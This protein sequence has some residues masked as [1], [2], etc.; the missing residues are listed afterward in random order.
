ML[1]TIDHTDSCVPTV[2]GQLMLWGGTMTDD[3]PVWLCVAGI[4]IQSLRLIV[5]CTRSFVLVVLL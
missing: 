5:A 4:L 1:G 3:D 2:I